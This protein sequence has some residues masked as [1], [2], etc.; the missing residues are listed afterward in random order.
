MGKLTFACPRTKQTIDPGID[1]DKRTFGLVR[2]VN[3][4]LQ[5]PHCGEEH[6]FHVA[7]GNLADAA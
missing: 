3:L 7:E 4:R 5:C 6:T 2:E 1:T